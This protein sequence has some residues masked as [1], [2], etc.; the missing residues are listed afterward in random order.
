M[1][2]PKKPKDEGKALLDFTRKRL[3]EKVKVSV[4][5]SIA[6]T[7]GEGDLIILSGFGIDGR[8]ELLKAFIKECREQLKGE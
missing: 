1:P 6:E 8:K 2:V 7:L 4:M 3:A 5:T